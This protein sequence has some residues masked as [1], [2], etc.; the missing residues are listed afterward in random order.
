MFLG[1]VDC[2]FIMVANTLGASFK[3][4]QACSLYRQDF[5]RLQEI[6]DM[7][8]SISRIGFFA[9]DAQREPLQKFIVRFN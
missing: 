1:T 2:C 3:Y 7:D 6:K 9:I 5:I 4:Q 8:D